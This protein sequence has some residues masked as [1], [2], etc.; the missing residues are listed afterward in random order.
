LIFIISHLSVKKQ[1]GALD[2]L[3]VLSKFAL[4]QAEPYYY[5]YALALLNRSPMDSA[6]SFLARYNEGLSPAKLLPAF[7][8][9]ERNRVSYRAT[10]SRSDNS[11]SRDPIIDIGLFRSSKD[12]FSFFVDDDSASMKFFEGVVTLG[13]KS[14]AI[15]DYLISLYTKMDD[16]MPLFRFLSIHIPQVTSLSSSKSTSGLG[17]AIFT[18]TQIHSSPLDMSYALRTILRSGRHYRS[19]VKLY[20][21]FGMRQQAVELAIKVDPILARELAKECVGAEER[22]RIWLMI[23]RQAAENVGNQGGKEVVAKVLSVI[24]ECGPEVLSIED[25]LPFL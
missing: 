10:V 4:E 24:R 1:T 21:G 18:Q 7:M 25:V 3:R 6:K 9:Y 14:R 13:C 16:E 22:K 11:K 23:A 2:A 19:A 17:S 12:P 5:K 20:M 15:F 8:Q